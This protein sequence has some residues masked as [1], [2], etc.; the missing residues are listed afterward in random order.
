MNQIN[1]KKRDDIIV[2]PHIEES[3]VAQVD[4]TSYV[5]LKEKYKSLPA[6]I[7][8]ANELIVCSDFLIGINAETKL[9]NKLRLDATQE[10][11]AVTENINNAFEPYIVEMKEMVGLIKDRI[12][13]YNREQERLALEV[14]AKAEAERR[15]EQERLDKERAEK[16]KDAIFPEEVPEVKAKPVPQF[17]PIAAAFKT[18]SG[19]VST[20][21]VVS[22]SKIQ[23][24]IDLGV[25]E[26]VGV[27][28]YPLWKFEIVEAEKVPTEY[29]EDTLATRRK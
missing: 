19:S 14:Q 22:H 13:S 18:S 29:R 7:S 27:L 10:Y 8:D 1:L 23:A 24:A 12:L 17:V 25:R 4:I 6:E 9:L 21:S 28:I 5:Q 26:I 2:L 15:T 3:G 16:Q 20:I 11:R